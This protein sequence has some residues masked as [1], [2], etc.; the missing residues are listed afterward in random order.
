MFPFD[1]PGPQFLLFYLVFAI[2]TVF[3]L[4]AWLRRQEG[5]AV[6]R[7]PWDDPL[8]IACLR[9][10]PK[11]V[12][13]IATFSLIDRGYLEVDDDRIG[14][15]G[16]RKGDTLRRSLERKLFEFF[17]TRR[18]AEELFTRAD[19]ATDAALYEDGLRKLRLL[20]DIAQ[21]QARNRLVLLAAG[22]LGGVAFVKILVALAQSRGNVWFLV[23]LTAGMTWFAMRRL[24]PRRTALGDAAV[25]DLRNLFGRL[26]SG[27]ARVRPGGATTEALTLAAVFGLGALPGSFAVKKVFAKAATQGD[28]SSSSSGSCGSSCGSSGGSGGDGGSGCGGGGG[29]GGCG[30]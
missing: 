15:A 6:P 20:P 29:C 23:L 18:P 14:V 1:L 3:G 4:R 11:E 9:G 19:L 13:R 24:R 8:Q 5:G 26:H 2:I 17:A 21:Q 12:L 10:G 7:L 25:E 28:G 22:L 30:G 16:K 27:R